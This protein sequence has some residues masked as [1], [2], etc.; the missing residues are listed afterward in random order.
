MAAITKR[1]DASVSLTSEPANIGS[2]FYQVRLDECAPPSFFVFLSEKRDKNLKILIFYCFL[3]KVANYGIGGR[4]TPHL[5]YGVRLNNAQ[6]ESF[7]GDRLLT[8]MIYVS[9][10]IDLDSFDKFSIHSSACSLKKQLEDVGA[11]GAT[12]FTHAG[13]TVRPRRGMAVLWWNLMSDLDGDLS[14]RHGG[15]PVL[16]GS[17]WSTPRA[18]IIQID[19]CFVY[20][21]HFQFNFSFQ[22]CQQ[23]VP[24]RVAD[25]EATMRHSTPL[26]N[27]LS[28]TS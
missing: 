16:Y 21:F 23:M 3:L 11:G 7:R 27:L 19:F 10:A 4:Y 24:Q 14:T 2:E 25:V 20:H 1:I 26:P 12:V 28:L 13:V 6:L 5:D 22:S 18:S 17:K 8:F 15:C 9:L